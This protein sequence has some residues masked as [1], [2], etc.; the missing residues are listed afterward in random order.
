MAAKHTIELRTLVEARDDA[1]EQAKKAVTKVSLE[2]AK[3]AG[4]VV[5][6]ENVEV[7]GD[8]GVER[9]FMA[10]GVQTEESVKIMLE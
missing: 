10:E 1:L 2:A 8:D 6:Q 7:Q 4:I 5:K 9:A 3:K